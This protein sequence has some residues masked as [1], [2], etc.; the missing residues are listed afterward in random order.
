MSPKVNERS[1]FQNFTCSARQLNVIANLE[2]PR[3]KLAPRKH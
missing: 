3:L 2:L 1:G